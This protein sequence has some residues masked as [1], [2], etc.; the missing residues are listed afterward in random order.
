MSER[1]ASNTGR[2]FLGF[3]CHPELKKEIEQE[4]EK[5]GTSISKV[6]RERLSRGDD[7]NS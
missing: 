2:S 1:S 5:R 6:A 7:H 4:A 3:Y